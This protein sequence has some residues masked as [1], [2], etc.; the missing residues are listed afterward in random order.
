[1]L[2]C[3]PGGLWVDGTLG[4][5][6]HAEAILRA[7]APGGLLLGLDRDADALER[8]RARLAPFGERAILQRA[9]FRSLPGI[10]DA[11]GGERPAGILLDLGLSSLQ[12]DDPARG[13][14]FMADGPLDMRM[15]RTQPRTAADLVNGLPRE[16]LAELFARYGEERQARRLAAAIARARARG[17][18][19]TTRRLAEIIEEATPVRGPRRIHPA[20]RVFQALRIAVNDELSGLDRLLDDVATRLQPRG[21]IAVIAFHSLE[22]RI[23][24]NAFRAL[25]ARCACPPRLPVCGCGRP[26]V[27]R[28]VTRKPVRPGPQEV[29]FNPRSR[30]AR[31]RVAER[32]ETP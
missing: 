11:L 17:P 9:D 30:S 1:M 16:A 25:A 4:A 23:V 2:A 18:I 32:L 8:A 22:D 21:R 26:D 7:T 3:R 12:L 6:G 20:T 13:F 31:L 24:K 27:V 29:R 28:L 14:S 15:D 5:G 19:P 10:L